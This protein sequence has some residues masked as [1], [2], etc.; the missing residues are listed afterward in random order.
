MAQ[1]QRKLDLTDVW[2]SEDIPLIAR[3]AAKRLKLMLPLPDENLDYEREEF[4]D[5]FEALSEDPD[6]DTSDFDDV[7][8][9]LY[10]WGD[11]SLDGKFNGKKVC[12]VAT[13]F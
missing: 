8:R 11:I 2:E 5:E 4:I 3:T 1:W 7:L 10:D 12:W 9:R 6:A 13:S